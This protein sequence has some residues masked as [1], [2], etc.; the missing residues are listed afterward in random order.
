LISIIA[1]IAASP[2]C[3]AAPVDGAD[4]NLKT[5]RVAISGN[6]GAATKVMIEVLKEGK[7]WAALDAPALEPAQVLD[8]LEW[9][10]MVES[11]ETGAYYASFETSDV[12]GAY[13]VRARAETGAISYYDG[14]KYFT[15]TDVDGALALLNAA[16]DA[17]F[18]G[19]LEEHY[20]KFQLDFSAYNALD[21]P[22]N[23]GMK[24]LLA[25]KMLE[26]R[27]NGF[28]DEESVRAAFGKAE[29]VVTLNTAGADALWAFMNDN[30]NMLEIKASNSWSIYTGDSYSQQQAVLNK[31][32]SGYYSSIQAFDEAFWDLAVLEGVRGNASY[33]I[34]K[35]IIDSADRLSNADLGAYKSLKN[36][37]SIRMV[38]TQINNEPAYA[39]I[40]ALA[41][42]ISELSAVQREGEARGQ[43][44]PARPSGGGGGSLSIPLPVPAIPK[45]EDMPETPAFSDLDNAEWAKEAIEALYKAGVVSGKGGGIFD[46]MAD[47]TR[48]EF[49][50]MLIGALAIPLDG[51]ASGFSDIGEGAWYAP[52]VSKAVQS[53]LVKGISSDAFGV[54]LPITRQDMAVIVSRACDIFSITGAF[55]GQARF[56]DADDIADYAAEAVAS[57]QASG[58]MTGM[59]D[60]RFAPLE[61]VNRA[62]TAKAL[63][64]IIKLKG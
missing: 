4:V 49:V 12:T 57:V 47:V 2:V 17:T 18:R 30:A 28:A 41:S 20:E 14:Y 56:T 32:A 45:A 50:K 46:P 31:L 44:E 3:A 48:E 25:A 37:S 13:A 59:G 5:R 42:K 40:D 53:G 34:T 35:H 64:E 21:T 1:L 16:T 29:L 7:A 39:T 15:Q 11:N 6:Y 8:I 24:D 43:N 38:C 54:G 52:Y 26:Q 55:G 51:E 22:T 23:E 36:A 63:Y 61:A 19:A 10:G 60:G 58:I 62:Q 33:N 27:G 9:V